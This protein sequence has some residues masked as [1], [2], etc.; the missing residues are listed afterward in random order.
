VQNQEPAEFH[1]PSDGWR[2]LVSR[3][4]DFPTTQLQNSGNKARMSMKTNSREV[5][6]LRSREA[7]PGSQAVGCRR[8]VTLRLSTLD[9]STSEFREQ[10]ENVYENKGKGQNVRKPGLRWP[11]IIAH[12]LTTSTPS[13][14]MGVG[15]SGH[16]Q[17][18][19]CGDPSSS[20]SDRDSSG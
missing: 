7:E 19:N 14:K 3:L 10:S 13:T 12:G 15:E 16:F 9:F 4:L 5:K 8:F 6:K 2:R 1:G 18:K 20:R 11:C 17:S